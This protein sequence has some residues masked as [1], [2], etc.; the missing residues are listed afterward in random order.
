MEE[1][2]ST[3][4]QAMTGVLSEISEIVSET[5]ELTEIFER[6]ADV[7]RRV[8]PF[9]D[10][11]IVRV[12]DGEKAILHAHTQAGKVSKG[13]LEPWPL[14][15]WSPRWRPRPEPV[16]RIEDARAELDPKF[17]VDGYALEGGLGSGMWEPFR[18]GDT[19]GGGVWLSSHTTH[20][21]RDEHQEMF[22]PIAALLGSA[23]EHWRIWDTERR[24]R[25]RLDQVENLLGTL[26]ESLD[27][28]EVFQ[29]LSTELKPILPHDLMNLTEL[30]LGGRTIRVVAFA[31][32]IEVRTDL[33]PLTGDEVEDQVD[34]AIVDDIC[35][36]IPADNERRRLIRGSGMR[37]WLHVPLWLSGEVRGSLSFLHR[38]PHRYDRED[39]EVALLVAARVALTLSFR[40]LS[41]Q[42]RL[43]AESRARA[44]R[45]E[46]TV[47]TLAR[48]LRSRGAGRVVG[49]SPAWKEVMRQVGRVASSET[50][51]L[52]TGESGTGKEVVSSLIHQGSARAEKA[53]VAINCAALPEQL[54]ESELFGHE[55]GAFTGAIAT[56]VGHLEQAEGGT[57]FLDEIA[58]MSP[59][60]QAKF[61]RVL[62][63]REF[64]RVGGERAIKADVR[65]I[66]ATNRNLAERIATQ[67][68]RED[69]FYRLNVFAI[70]IAP[71]RERSED[72]LPMAEAFLEDLG[73]LMGR[74]VAG[75]SNEAREWLLSYAW[76]G[77]VREL[78][79]A[80][81]RAILLCDGGLI[82]REHLPRPAAEPADPG[83]EGVNLESMERRLIQRALDQASG[84]KSRAAK[85]LGLTRAQLYTRL[86]KHGIR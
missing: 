80:M 46:A 19:F 1:M 70:H 49:D 65:V 39:A 61:L 13:H 37:S 42:A 24:R 9:E 48:E 74:S 8:I 32:D 25:E 41:D 47:E 18:R 4:T 78:R 56:K 68:F 63:T 12:V 86:E 69:L 27:V 35:K 66:A 34:F 5:M 6:V 26:A 31:G 21:F 7:V 75:I 15:A 84:N 11:G 54:L 44:E 3:D 77:N 60:V 50:T 59:Q 23:V 85:L 22:K 51:V 20:A 62:E 10:M 57:L 28:R 72:I 58:E 64:Q 38:E 17:P 29:R 33:F 76:P 79:N 45:L 43:T 36:E 83:D 2:A 53:L 82:T 67:L 16:P 14:T 30:D 52:I 73:R 71:L 81:E 55:K 40:K